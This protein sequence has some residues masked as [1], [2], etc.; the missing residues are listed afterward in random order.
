MSQ[1]TLPALKL[2]VATLFSGDWFMLGP[3]APFPRPEMNDSTNKQSLRG[4]Q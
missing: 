2:R 1:I 4:E 3:K